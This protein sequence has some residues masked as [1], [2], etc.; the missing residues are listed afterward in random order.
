MSSLDT[1]RL[2]VDVCDGWGVV[3]DGRTDDG[4]GVGLSLP[5]HQL[6]RQ[7]GN[8]E[9]DKH[10]QLASR[11]IVQRHGN[12]RTKQEH[13]PSQNLFVHPSPRLT[14]IAV[15]PNPPA[16]SAIIGTSRLAFNGLERTSHIPASM[17]AW[18]LS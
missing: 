11:L 3:E 12:C 4:H 8:E 13:S 7:P 15:G 17:A 2:D 10:E 14:Q 5:Q 6:D 1:P 9:K 18:S 16:T